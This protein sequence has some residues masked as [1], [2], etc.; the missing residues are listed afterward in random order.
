MEIKNIVQC[1]LYNL[2][3]TAWINCNPV[4]SGTS[5]ENFKAMIK[6]TGLCHNQ[7]V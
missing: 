3:S 5:A 2:Y 4:F 6:A 1:V 7:A